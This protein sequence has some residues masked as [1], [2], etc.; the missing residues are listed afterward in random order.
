MLID[1][2]YI[3]FKNIGVELEFLLEKGGIY[4]F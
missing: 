2:D 1:F 3:M 4:Y